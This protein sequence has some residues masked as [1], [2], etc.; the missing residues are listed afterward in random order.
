MCLLIV[1][2][3]G[4]SP[5]PR[6]LWSAGQ[7]NPDGFG[8]AVV[9]DGTVHVGHSLDLGSAIDEFAIVRSR[10]PNNPALFH[11]RWATHGSVSTANVHPFTVPDTNG[12]VVVA[13][14]GILPCDPPKGSDWSD[15]KMFT[16]R[17]LNVADLDTPGYLEG[18]SRWARGSKLAILSADPR[19]SKSLYMVNE[20]DGFTDDDDGC[21]YS[22][23]SGHKS[24]RQISTIADT[25]RDSF[26][27]DD[28]DDDDV[29]G[30]GYY[31]SVCD[32]WGG[33]CYAD[34]DD[35]CA[36][37]SV[38]VCHDCGACLDC[39]EPWDVCLCY[40]PTT[41]DSDDDFGMFV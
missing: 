39:A 38:G 34:C 2:P 10:F 8:F 7:S 5:D 11:L 3:A 4:T 41:Y 40:A 19:L 26:R 17:I 25:F 18:L 24:N 21:F 16:E 30:I 14:N 9:G 6:R 32:D 31:C 20:S 22:N 28:D 15:T 29:R 36:T 1:S 27:W 37:A 23:R 33:T 13:H 35:D 12:N